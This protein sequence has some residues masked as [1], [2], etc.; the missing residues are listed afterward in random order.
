MKPGSLAFLVCGLLAAL[1]ISTPRATALGEEKPITASVTGK[2][3]EREKTKIDSEKQG[4]GQAKAETYEYS[5]TL[6]SNVNSPLSGVKIVLYVVGELYRFDERD[7]IPAVVEII[8]TN[9][10]QLGPL[11]TIQ[12]EI[13]SYT[14]EI[15]HSEKPSGGVTL[16]WM[17]GAGEFGFIAEVYVGEKLID[18]LYGRGS[19]G[20]L[21]D[22][23]EAY[24]ANKD[25]SPKKKKKNS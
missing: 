13:G 7:N 5:A 25:K 11:E 18:T 15:R 16:V 21:K 22:A 3:L 23:L 14:F 24:Q 9:S 6:Q 10:L 17:N 2:K 1:A 12:M 8:H 4:V 20:K 19:T